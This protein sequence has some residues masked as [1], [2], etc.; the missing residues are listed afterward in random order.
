[1]HLNE[2]RQ[3]YTVMKQFIWN[4][5]MNTELQFSFGLYNYSS[6]HLS[7][8][9]S[10]H[11]SAAYMLQWIGSALVKVMTCRQF[12]AKSLPEPILTSYQLNPLEQTSVKLES[13]YKTFHSW[14]CIWICRLW[15][16]GHFVGGGGGLV[17]SWMVYYIHF[18]LL[19][20]AL[21]AVTFQLFWNV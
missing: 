16:I 13:T 8:V 20:Y 5:Y 4:W 19:I 7:N 14:K 2:V 9:N 3:E 6:M 1:M 15:N 21:D 17:K 12:G 11:P 10:S 18:W